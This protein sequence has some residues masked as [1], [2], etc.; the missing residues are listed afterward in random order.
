MFS[1]FAC[2][3]LVDL[4]Q[5][6]RVP[7]ASRPLFRVSPRSAGQA[8]YQPPTR[9]APNLKKWPSPP[10]V[11]FSDSIR[12][13]CLTMATKK[14]LLASTVSCCCCVRACFAS[15]LTMEVPLP[16]VQRPSP[17]GPSSYTYVTIMIKNQI[18]LPGIRTSDV[19]LN[20]GI[21]AGRLAIAS[22]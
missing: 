14:N 1:C 6:W 16:A 22:N 3:A 13:L 10:D 20:F 15:V 5:S 17:C 7:P 9:H 21:N 18:D 11:V 19:D 12:E 2:L 4:C 8:A